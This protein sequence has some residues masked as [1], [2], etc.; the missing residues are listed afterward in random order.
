M[1]WRAFA[2]RKGSEWIRRTMSAASGL[3]I[4]GR[5]FSIFA[6]CAASWSTLLT[7]ADMQRWP[8][9]VALLRDRAF[10]ASILI[11]CARVSSGTPLKPSRPVGIYHTRARTL[12]GSAPGRRHEGLTLVEKLYF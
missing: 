4:S 6:A 8:T 12:A 1:C 10:L 11:A 3:S 2:C 5:T 9:G 7:R